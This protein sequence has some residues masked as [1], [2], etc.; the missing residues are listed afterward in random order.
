[1]HIFLQL[2]KVIKDRSWTVLIRFPGPHCACGCGDTEIYRSTFK[3]KEKEKWSLGPH[4]C[5][6]ITHVVMCFEH[7]GNFST[8]S[9]VLFLEPLQGHHLRRDLLQLLLWWQRRPSST[10]GVSPLCCP[11]T[12]MRRPR[13]AAPGQGSC[14]SQADGAWLVALP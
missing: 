14:F 11:R 5:R 1:M 7:M 9:C 4:H 10:L 13:G 6:E 2:I 8:G 12:G 3:K